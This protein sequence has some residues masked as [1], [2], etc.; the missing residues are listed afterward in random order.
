MPACPAT[1]IM[2]DPTPVRI[3]AFQRKILRFYERHGR[4]LLFR[5]TDN[6][7]KITVAEIMLQQTQV[8]RVLPF[9][10][11]WIKKWP[12]WEA[13]ARASDRE[14]LAMWSGLGYNRR[15]RYLGRL[16]RIVISDYNG[17]LPDDPGVLIKLP[18]IGPYTSRA[19][20]ILAFDRPLAAVDT[21]VRRVLIHEFGL[22]GT[23][24]NRELEGFALQLVPPRRAR[25]WL[26]ALMDYS[27]LALPRRMPHISPA[28]RPSRFA[29]SRRQI[30]GEIIRRLTAR[31]RTTVAAVARHLDLPA[32][33]VRAAV[34]SLESEGFVVCTGQ[35]VCPHREHCAPRLKKRV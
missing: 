12:N 16:A 31:S 14:L 32:E 33:D 23:I 35:T 9:Y 15:A 11:H 24:T 4:H 18:G 21:N 3:R 25:D 34:R 19:I 7:Y 13:L 8:D 1:H 29:G 28:S 2:I 6:P 27:R 10:Q 26:N 30:R 5:L 22:P 17:K 20:P